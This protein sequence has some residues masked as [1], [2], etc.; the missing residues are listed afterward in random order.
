MV[1]ERCSNSSGKQSRRVFL[2]IQTNRIRQHWS[3]KNPDDYLV[4]VKCRLRGGKG[5]PKVTNAVDER[6]DEVRSML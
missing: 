4:P 6:S 3:W 1:V 5:L 2:F